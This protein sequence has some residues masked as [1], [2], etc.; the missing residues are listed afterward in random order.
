MTKPIPEF[1]RRGWALTL[2][3]VV[4][5]LCPTAAFA[6]PSYCECPDQATSTQGGSLSQNTC[7]NL[8]ENLYGNLRSVANSYCGRCGACFYSYTTEYPS[9]TMTGD[10]FYIQSGT[11]TYACG[12]YTG[13][14]S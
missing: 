4:A 12:I 7:W 11:L 2:L 5:I 14:D 3:L 13:P 10:G 8:E 1:L 9:C 6:V